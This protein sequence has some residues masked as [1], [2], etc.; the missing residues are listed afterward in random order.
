MT[1][2]NAKQLDIVPK[3]LVQSIGLVIVLVL[4]SVFIFRLMD[5]PLIGIAPK[6]KVVKEINLNFVERNRFD[7]VVLDKYDK[8]LVESTDGAN[9]SPI[10]PNVLKLFFLNDEFWNND[11]IIL[12][13]VTGKYNISTFNRIILFNIFLSKIN[14][15]D[16]N[17]IVVE[18][19]DKG[20]KSA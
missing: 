5:F 8:V 2:S 19:I 10:D 17:N 9:G 18:P 3:R 6:A 7:V 11:F 15:G 4:F 20:P 12:I 14:K 13:I 16:C 1:T